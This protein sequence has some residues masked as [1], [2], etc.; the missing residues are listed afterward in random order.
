MSSGRHGE[1][2]RS[3]LT[4]TDLIDTLTHKYHPVSRLAGRDFP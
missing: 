2:D 4:V 1:D 3:L